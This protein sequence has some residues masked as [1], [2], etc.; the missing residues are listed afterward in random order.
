VA[1]AERKGNTLIII[2]A[3]VA[4]GYGYVAGAK[5][6]RIRSSV[7]LPESQ[8]QILVLTVLYVPNL[9]DSGYGSFKTLNLPRQSVGRGW[10][11]WRK[12]YKMSTFEGIQ[13]N[14]KFSKVN[15]RL[16]R[17]CSFELPLPTLWRGGGYVIKLVPEKGSN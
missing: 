11:I 5:N 7:F 13:G 14:L 2:R 10:S 4:V 12:W 15:L 3:G 1:A 8:D 6:I 9:L 17:R 16:H